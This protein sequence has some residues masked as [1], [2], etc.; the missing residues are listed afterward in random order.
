MACLK[1]TFMLYNLTD[2]ELESI[3]DNMFLCSVEEN[4]DIF[5]E[6]DDGTCFFIVETGS[7]ELRIDDAL[8][9][10]IKPGEGNLKKNIGF[11]E[12]ALLYKSKRISTVKTVE[13][14]KLWAIDRITFR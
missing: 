12:I 9:R 6:N 8:K 10:E 2:T 13:P 1:N 11:G 7:L 5:K 4:I 3:R 14:C